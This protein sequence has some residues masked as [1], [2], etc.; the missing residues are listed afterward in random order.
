M[1]NYYPSIIA[2]AIFFAAI[3]ISLHDGQKLSALIMSLLAIPFIL[4]IGYLSQEH[5]HIHAYLLILIPILI[6]YIGYDM[7]LPPTPTPTPPIPTPPTL[8]SIPTTTTPPITPT[9]PTVPTLP[10]ILTTPTTDLPPTGPAPVKTKDSFINQ[11]IVPDRIEPE[12]NA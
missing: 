9:I 11:P 4:F 10:S 7:G 8:P 6:L 12:E 3:V 1:S 2:S 5:K